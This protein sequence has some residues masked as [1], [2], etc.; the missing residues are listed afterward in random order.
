MY[1]T[2]RGRES[3]IFVSEKKLECIIIVCRVAPYNGGRR[4]SKVAEVKGEGETSKR[5]SSGKWVKSGL[6]KRGR[7]SLLQYGTRRGLANRRPSR[8]EVGE[9]HRGRKAS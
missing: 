7:P 5:E 8:R 4:K 1:D 2:R 3:W 9:E 6:C